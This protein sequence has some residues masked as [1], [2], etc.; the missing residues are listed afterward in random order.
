MKK[1]FICLTIA[2][3]IA[4]AA[5]A[6]EYKTGLGYRG[7]F[8]NG[9]TVKHFL[10]TDVAMEGLLTARYRGFNLTGLYEIHTQPF[11]IEHM[12]F[13]YGFGGHL[14]SWQNPPDRDWWNDGTNHSIIGID[15]IIGVEYDLVSI[16]F[17]ISLDY[18][19]GI[20]I[21][22]YPKI[23]GDEFSISIR[24]LWGNR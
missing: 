20:N 13:Y 23:W 17:N 21:I 5:S 12:Y 24:Y 2:A 10:T 4:T 1:L 14:G 11:G 8:S 7:G 9:L 19:P 22:G 6:Q 16:P 18:K 3:L 15:G